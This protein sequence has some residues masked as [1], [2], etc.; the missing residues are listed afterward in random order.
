LTN[1]VANAANV[2]PEISDVRICFLPTEDRGLV[3]W[4]TCVIDRAIKLNN[5]ALR[6]GRD[7]GLFLTF[8]TKLAPSGERRFHFHPISAAATALLERAILAKAH[9]LADLDAAARCKT[10][11]AS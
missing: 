8:P 4:I 1:H 5:I 11:G 6:R 9:E 10:G 2:Q 7:G 3:A